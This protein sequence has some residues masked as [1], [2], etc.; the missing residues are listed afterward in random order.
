MKRV[1]PEE[2]AEPVLLAYAGHHRKLSPLGT[3]IM[4]AAWLF[5]LLPVI[6][7]YGT[8][9]TAWFSLGHRPAPSM[10]DPKEI[11]ALVSIAH[12]ITVVSFL[13]GTFV[14]IAAIPLTLWWAR[15][16]GFGLT[17]GAAI[18]LVLIGIYVCEVGVLRS[19]P[20]GVLYWF[21]D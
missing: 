7:L 4:I 10:D 5:P 2:P 17:G 16:R 14:A 18:A 11:G 8:W 12:V 20:M 19:D 1:S 13:Y 15:A 9:L 3:T 6:C 21:M